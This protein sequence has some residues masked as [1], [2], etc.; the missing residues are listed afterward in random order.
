M[1]KYIGK[2]ISYLEVEKNY[3]PHTVLN[4]RKDLEE[5]TAHLGKTPLAKVEYMMLRKFLADLR[6]KNL[7]PRSLARKM[8]TLRSFFRFLQKEGYLKDNPAALL[9]T[10]KL[11]KSL[12]K[13]LTEEEMKKYIEAPKEDKMFSKRNRAILEMLYSTGMRVSE[14]VGLNVEHVDFFGQIVKVAGKGKKERLIPIGDTALKAIKSYL[15]ERKD[16]KSV[17]FLNKNGTRISTRGVCDVTHKYLHQFG[18]DKKISPHVLRH[19]FATHLLDRG[20][21]L[22]S[23]QELLGHANLSTTQIYTHVTTDRLKKVYDKAHPRA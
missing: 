18:S 19:S 10:P 4:Y 2:F 12:P 23:V 16:K 8:S 22:R 6:G 20:A 3:S 21:D 7:K 15:D 5:F 1:E 9:M 17:L 14:L 13:F 11:D